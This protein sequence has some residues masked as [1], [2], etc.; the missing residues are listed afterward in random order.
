MRHH[1]PRQ[2][3]CFRLALELVAQHPFELTLVHGVLTN[4]EG[5]EIVHA[6]AE[7]KDLGVEWVYDP[8]Q[9]RHAPKNDYYAVGRVHS[10][11]RYSAFHA[12]DLA[13]ASD[14]HGPWDAELVRR[15]M[16]PFIGELTR[17]ARRWLQANFPDVLKTIQAELT[18]AKR[19]KETK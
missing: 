4:L 16:G 19:G 7:F 12:L 6:W 15:P 2:G 14:L 3:R 10:T 17:P 9:Q 18:A 8:V 5:R 11:V 1:N 13:K